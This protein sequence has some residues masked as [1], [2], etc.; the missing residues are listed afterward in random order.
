M[1]DRNPLPAKKGE[2]RITRQDKNKKGMG[3]QGEKHKR[4]SRHVHDDRHNRKKKPDKH[5]GY[6]D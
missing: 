6:P 1:Q 4:G 5:Y 3:S 2:P